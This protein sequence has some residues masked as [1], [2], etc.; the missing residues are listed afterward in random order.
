MKNG[1]RLLFY[2]LL[3]VLVSALTTA[4][5]LWAWQR[6]LWPQ[7]TPPISG[8]VRVTP[9]PPVTPVQGQRALLPYQV[10]PGDSWQSIAEAFHT[11]VED[12]Q[13]LNGLTDDAPPGIGQVLM[14]PGET[15]T[16]TPVSA[17]PQGDPQAVHIVA[18]VGAGDLQSEYIQLEYSGEGEL[19][20]Q[21]WQ[22]RTPDALTYT[23]PA[24]T[25][26]AGGAIRLHTAAG[27]DT[28][29]DLYWGLDSP[30]WASGQQ[31]A[32]LTPDGTIQETFRVP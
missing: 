27:L 32:L 25:L 23:F 13:R 5:V 2:L 22:V 7:E 28:V 10:Q 20:L 17:Q 29:V 31:I 30:L 16:P 11:S 6:Y 14:V 19:S 3:N 4:T 26:H 15:L 21:G 8:Q 1:K 18:V 12:L 24:L 9:A